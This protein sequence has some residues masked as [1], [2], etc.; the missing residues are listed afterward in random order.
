MARS[1]PSSAG[2]AG[3]PPSHR[4]MHGQRSA[5]AERRGESEHDLPR[6]PDPSPVADLPRSRWIFCVKG[7]GGRG[8]RRKPPARVF[9]AAT[10]IPI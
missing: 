2:A 10:G 7:S 6:P 5:T 9:V 1:L 4:R 3:H 8:E